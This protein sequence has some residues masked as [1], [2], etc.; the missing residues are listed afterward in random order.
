MKL[1]AY[2]LGSFEALISKDEASFANLSKQAPLALQAPVSERQA[3]IID[4]AAKAIRLSAE[5][6]S[7][8]PHVSPQFVDA[9]C[10]VLM[11]GRFPDS[12]S[13]AR[14]FAARGARYGDIAEKLFGAAARRLGNKWDSDAATVVEVN[15]GV[16][17]LVRTH[18]ALCSRGVLTAQ[19]I[20][21]SAIF[22]SIHGQAH[23]LGLTF[24][25]EH[26]RRNGWN[27]HYMTATSPDELLAEAR[28]KCPKLVGLTAATDAD[29]PLIRDVADRFRK[30]PHR[31]RI[32]I[33]G[34]APN[35]TSLGADI[36]V[37]RLNMG[38]IAAGSLL[39]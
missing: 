21:G 18:V 19:P 32:M 23:T 20:V 14:S 34:A 4:L 16:A 28:R 35:L 11:K 12:L 33:G 22:A 3:T 7:D 30:L 29:E 36:V 5:S 1:A 24:A 6:L 9:F 25:A 8:S 38:L 31:P 26:F 27:I 17:T 15:I 10:H 39:S 37:S 2:E 13:L